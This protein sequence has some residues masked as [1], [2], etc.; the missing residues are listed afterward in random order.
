MSQKK[1]SAKASPFRDEE[2]TRRNR[3]MMWGRLPA[4]LIGGGAMYFADAF[5]P[6]M[7]VLALWYAIWLVWV[8]G[9]FDH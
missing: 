2:T 6:G 5:W 8:G 4:L 7:V 3:L 9:V 1:Q